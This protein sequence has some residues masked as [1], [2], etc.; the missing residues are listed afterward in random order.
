MV[1]RLQAT[2]R[3]EK[4]ECLFQIKSEKDW[5]AEDRDESARGQIGKVGNEVG[6]HQ[7]CFQSNGLAGKES[8]A[9]GRVCR[10]GTGA[11]DVEVVPLLGQESC[12]DQSAKTV[13]Q[14]F[15]SD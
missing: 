5:L 6:C 15:H 12:S 8:Q 9:I 4:A 2:I 7:D 1:Q 10:R 11:Q 14:S 13:N 3:D